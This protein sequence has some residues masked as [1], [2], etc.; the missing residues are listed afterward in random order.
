MNT[1]CR[2]NDLKGN[3]KFEN[4]KLLTTLT[5]NYISKFNSI[6]LVIDIDNKIITKT[7]YNVRPGFKYIT[8][9]SETP[10]RNYIKF[11]YTE[12]YF[13]FE[14]EK[15]IVSA[16]K[17]FDIIFP[18]NINRRISKIFPRFEDKEFLFEVLTELEKGLLE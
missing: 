2:I 13:D 15:Q 1:N 12:T 18:C 16:E 7:N 11:K 9:T 17:E 3:S 6:V 4:L 5:A 10:T 8:V 14:E